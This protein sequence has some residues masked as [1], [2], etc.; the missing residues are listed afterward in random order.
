MQLLSN[1]FTYVEEVEERSE[2]LEKDLS[3]IKY[4]DLEGQYLNAPVRRMVWQTILV[5]RE[6]VN[7]L[8]NEPEKIFVEM[9]RD[10][11][12]DPQRTV[13]SF[14]YTLNSDGKDLD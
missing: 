10:K 4:E 3:E 11:E 13:S 2:K 12:I 7:V 14:L 5:V 9:A 8:G 6:L 1:H